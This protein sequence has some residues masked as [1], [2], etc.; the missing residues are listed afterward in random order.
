MIHQPAY[1]KALL[2]K[3]LNGTATAVEVAR[4]MAAWDIYDDEELSNMIAEITGDATGSETGEGETELPVEDERAGPGNASSTPENKLLK[5]GSRF[6]RLFSTGSF[7]IL[8]CS[9]IWFFLKPDARTTERY[10]NGVPGHMELSTAPYHCKLMPANGS[11]LFI[12]GTLEGLVTQEGD[13]TITQPE[14]GVLVYE[15][16]GVVEKGNPKPLYHTI[17]TPPGQQ[18]RLVLPDGSKVRLNAAS[19]IS[20]A[21]NF[22]S[23]QR[24]VYLKGEAFFEVV[25]G[26]V[27]FIAEAGLTQLEMQEATFNVKAYSRNTVTTIQKGS[28]LVKA[29]SQTAR[30]IAGEKTTARVKIL[31]AK[32]ELLLTEE[33]TMAAL[34]WK[35]VTR[36]YTNVPMREFVSDIGR[37]YNVEMVN[38]SCIPAATHINIMMCYDL[39]IDDVLKIISDAKLKFYKVGNRITFCDPALRE[40]PVKEGGEKLSA[41]IHHQV[42]QLIQT[43]SKANDIRLNHFI[44]TVFSRYELCGPFFIFNTVS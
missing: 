23:A 31:V 6:E 19:S 12:D 25:K 5:K 8:V 17:V 20:F 1:V 22:G 27:P 3:Y 37:R 39:P 24:L 14:P 21:A 38:L 15:R 36:V 43:A 41:V 30:L 4:L 11:H 44:V 2:E 13:V 9:L 35:K 16:K 29:G 42:K 40:E 26:N 7:I 10:C 32:D 18:Y 33:D 34:S 28:V